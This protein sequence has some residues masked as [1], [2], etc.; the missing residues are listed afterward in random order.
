MK[1]SSRGND[2]IERVFYD[3]FVSNVNDEVARK[4]IGSRE[5]N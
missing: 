4:E 2:K 1:S 5:N 3:Q